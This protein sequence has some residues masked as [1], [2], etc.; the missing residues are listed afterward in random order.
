MAPLAGTHGRSWW[1]RDVVVGSVTP[2]KLGPP[3]LIL[4][5]SPGSEQGGR[6][7]Q[8]QQPWGKGV[9]S[10]QNR[11]AFPPGEG[12]QSSCL[13]FPTGLVGGQA[14]RR[15]RQRA[16]QPTG[17]VHE[18][19]RVC[20]PPPKRLRACPGGACRERVAFPLAPVWLR[21]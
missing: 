5:V 8:E 11:G 4:G 1:G 14:G 10:A 13:S 16:L 7:P 12:K 15:C 20:V 18:W 3:G 2:A 19:V 21:I 6:P 9:A 17:S